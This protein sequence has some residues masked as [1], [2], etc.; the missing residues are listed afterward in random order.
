[1]NNGEFNLTA[2]AVFAGCAIAAI[3]G[4]GIEPMREKWTQAL[5]AADKE[6]P[7]MKDA[8]SGAGKRV[9][10]RAREVKAEAGPSE[11]NGARARAAG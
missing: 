2:R 8:A 5:A 7:R 11:G 3:G 10:H 4:G 1:M 9:E 6:A